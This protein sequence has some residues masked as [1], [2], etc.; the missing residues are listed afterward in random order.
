M[1][2]RQARLRLTRNAW[3]NLWET[4]TT[5]A[6][7]VFAEP[8]DLPVTIQNI[9]GSFYRNTRTDFGTTYF[10]NVSTLTEARTV[11]VIT[12]GTAAADIQ[13][14]LKNPTGL[15][16]KGGRATESSARGSRS[17]VDV[18]G[19]SRIARSRAMTCSDGVR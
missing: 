7:R 12:D 13:M 17:A 10:G 18:I 4:E 19:I 15:I 2:N 5:T 14:L 9:G 16:V 1:I 6:D 3:E 8:L 11:N